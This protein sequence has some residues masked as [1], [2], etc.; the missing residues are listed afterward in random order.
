MRIRTPRYRY[1]LM[2]PLK[3]VL[4]TI[5]GKMSHN[6]HLNTT[7]P[8]SNRLYPR[9]RFENPAGFSL[10]LFPCHDINSIV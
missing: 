3:L 1:A 9:F 7:N 8:R 4:Q 10:K 5:S 2:Q 6:S